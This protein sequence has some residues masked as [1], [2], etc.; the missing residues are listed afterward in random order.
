MRKLLLLLMLLGTP[1]AIA[2]SAMQGLDMSSPK[3]TEA[4]MSRA[5]I[6]ALI[7]ADDP[8]DLTR[9]MLNGLDL[10]GLTLDGAV[11]RAARMNGVS[12][13]GASL[14]GAVFDQA[15]MLKADLSGADLT[16]AS[17]FQTQL[18]GAD[19]H[20]ADLSQSRAA[21]DFTRADLSGARFRGADFSADM[22]NQSMGMMRGVLRKARAAGADFT[23]ANMRHADLE[24]AALTGADFTGADL[25]SSTLGG[26]DLTGATMTGA[27]LAE[28]D[29]ASTRL[30]DVT[31]L[32]EA[33]LNRARNLDRAIRD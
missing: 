15:W 24:F 23:G 2:Q 21:A 4:E 16:G 3:M 32:D 19:L 31:G 6:E 18:G 22:K 10:S 33:E 20:D 13:A 25:R 30:R 12:L 17:L 29:L 14:R 7:A 26:A 11:F 27:R 8:L 1:Q 5:D 28:A 9:K